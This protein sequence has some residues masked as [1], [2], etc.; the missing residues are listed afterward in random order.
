MKFL[1][2]AQLPPRLKQWL[3]EHGAESTLHVSDLSHGLRMADA[4]LWKVAKEKDC[5][6]VTKDMDFFD[7][8]ALYGS[9]PKVLL[10]R[11][12]NCSTTGMLANLSVIWPR[13]RPTLEGRNT[14]LVIITPE[15]LEIHR[16]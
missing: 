9:P 4:E 16:V 3:S 11:Y 8:S 5:I 2:D 10:I 14:R 7:L 13:L 15:R 12:G 1:V 6:I